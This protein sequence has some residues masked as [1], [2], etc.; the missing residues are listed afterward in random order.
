MFLLLRIF[1]EIMFYLFYFIYLFL[2]VLG[3]LSCLG[4]SLAAV[5]KGYSLVAVPIE[6]SKHW[7]S[8]VAT[9]GLSSRGAGAYMFHG[10]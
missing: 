7:A 8:V 3:L 1:F 4:F 6:D 10:M 9:H 5:S 2:S